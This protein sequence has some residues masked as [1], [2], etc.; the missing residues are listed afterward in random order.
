M[1]MNTVAADNS[2]PPRLHAETGA[3]LLQVERR[4]LEAGCNLIG[5]P[6]NV[7]VIG[8]VDEYLASVTD[9]PTCPCCRRAAVVWHPSRWWW[10]C[11]GCDAHYDREHLAIAWRA[12]WCC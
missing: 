12:A 2:S 11:P 3:R 4:H 9:T 7:V 1:S 6:D 10:I 5:Y 8:M